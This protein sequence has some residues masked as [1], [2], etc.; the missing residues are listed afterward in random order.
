MFQSC[1]GKAV[2]CHNHFQNAYWYGQ[3]TFIEP[4]SSKWIKSSPIQHYF[5][6]SILSLT[7]KMLHYRSEENCKCT[8]CTFR[9]QSAIL[10]TCPALKLLCLQRPFDSRWQKFPSI[11]YS[12]HDKV[13][14][15]CSGDFNQA[16]LISLPIVCPSFIG[17]DTGQGCMV[18]RADP[19]SSDI[20]CLQLIRAQSMT[21]TLPTISFPN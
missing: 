16:F 4:I 9:T 11:N 20:G 18:Y 1:F 14:I 12:D 21:V 7:S 2:D 6:R 10:K 19:Q 17:S 5:S 13:L 15:F 3:L 8:S